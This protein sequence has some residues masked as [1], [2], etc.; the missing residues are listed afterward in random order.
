MHI[1]SLPGNYGI[2][3]MGRSAREFV[4]FLED[5]GQSYWQVLPL[6]PTGFGDSPYQSFCCE[7]GNPYFIDLDELK[8][9]GLLEKKDLEDIEW[10]SSLDRVDYGIMYKERF[11]VLR[12]AVKAFLE[13]PDDKYKGFCRE[14][15]YWLDGYSLFMAVKDCSGGKP[16]YEWESAYRNMDSEEDEKFR[17]EHRDDIRF[18]KVVQYFFFK[19]WH[20]LKDYANEKGISIIGDLP[21]YVSLDSVSVWTRPELFQLDE[22]GMPIEVAGC[23]PDGFSDDGQL[24]GNPLY[25]WAYLEKDGYNWWIKRIDYLCHVFDVL[26]IDHFRGFESYYAVPYGETTA[27]KGRWRPG[28]GTDF[29]KKV[30]E[31]L[32]SEKII[33]EDLGF[34]TPQV[35]KMLDESGFPGMKVLEF[36]FDSRDRGTNMYL[37]HNYPENCV[38]YVG[39]HDNDTAVGWYESLSVWEKD[40]AKTYMGLNEQEGIAW[41]MMRNIWTSRAKITVVQA[42]DLLEL[43]SEARMNIPSTKGA[44]WTWRALPG[45]FSEKLAARM[46]NAAEI[47]GRK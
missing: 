6:C 37:P 10:G 3:T 19:Q 30:K 11:K 4:D 44:N 39:T 18:W 40:Y 45:S 21:I 13:D 15:L 12:K 1:S 9:E 24:W 22:N 17:A 35:Y 42:Q 2:G 33:A 38:A 36:A 26:R 31:S 47:Y 43:G 25:N 14:N 5:A 34:L 46:N 32:G 16:W 27:R 8:E 20:K 28:P 29:F 41:G 23:P 7:A